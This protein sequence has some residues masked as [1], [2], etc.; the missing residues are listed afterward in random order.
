MTP[1]EFKA[2]REKLGLTQRELAEGLGLKTNSVARMERGERP[3]RQVTRLA[4]EHLS[5]RP[6]R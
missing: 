6:R 5:C 3:I 1:A 4:I 2:I